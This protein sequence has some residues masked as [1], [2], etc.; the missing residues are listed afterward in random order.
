[1]GGEGPGA[2]E[3]PEPTDAPQE[4]TPTDSPIEAEGTPTDTPADEESP[5]ETETESP[6][7]GDDLDDVDVEVVDA[8]ENLEVTDYGLYRAESAVGLR[9]TIENTGE[10]AYEYVQVEVT[11]QDDQGD[12]LYEFVDETETETVSTIQPGD[13]WEFDVVFE[14]AE[15]SAVTDFSIAV[16]GYPTGETDFGDIEGEVDQQ[17]A[18][19]DITSHHLT[20][21]E[22]RTFVTGTVRNTGDA[23]VET[24][25]V[26]VTLYENE[27]NEL[28]D[29]TRSVEEDAERTR[30]TPGEVWEFRV[31]FDDVDLDT[32]GRYVVTARSASVE[33]TPTTGT[34]TGSD[35]NGT[36]SNETTSNG[37][38]SNETTSG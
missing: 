31:E 25:D 5:T 36:V 21:Q 37:T 3:S 38:V 4:G 9:G 11:L 19:L 8:E 14:E 33:G 16:D 7:Q 2:D 34:P 12:L 10:Q 6:S 18:D 22:S 15:M 30:L 28:A 24:V 32:V 35:A 20:R 1:M 13:E 26:S 27:T 29:F 23:A 17:E